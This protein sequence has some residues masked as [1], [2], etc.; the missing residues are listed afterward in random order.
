MAK[1][2]MIG[3]AAGLEYASH[4]LYRPSSLEKVE[5][6]RKGY[7]VNTGLIYM[8]SQT[9]SAFYLLCGAGFREAKYDAPL[10]LLDL[11]PHF[12][13]TYLYTYATILYK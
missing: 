9:L 3:S 11:K 6:R 10:R 2:E 5:M 8:Y 7:G 13:L 1:I 4:V 12:L